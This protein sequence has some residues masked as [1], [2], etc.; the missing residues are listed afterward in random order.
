MVTS[1]FEILPAIDLRGGRV[2]RLVQGDF[3]QETTFS[4]DPVAVARG[5]ADA[6]A[7]WLH[8]VDLDGARDGV[9]GHGAVTRAIVRAVGERLSV[10][11]AGGI[12]DASAAAN[13]IKSG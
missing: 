2:V 12:R 1:G 5:F 7:R 4:D 8:V 10:E 6:G 3:T 13:A 11:V 9:P